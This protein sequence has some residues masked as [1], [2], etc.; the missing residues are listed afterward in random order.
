MTAKE[1]IA[2]NLQLENYINAMKLLLQE[3]FN[4]IKSL[5]ETTKIY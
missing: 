1:L 4:R 3:V 5:V 2:D